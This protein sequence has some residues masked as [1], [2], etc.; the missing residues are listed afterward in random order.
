MRCALLLTLYVICNTLEAA[1]PSG[2]SSYTVEILV[3]RN[4]SGAR[5][6]YYVPS[7]GA[8][9]AE[10]KNNS[11]GSQVAQFI[12]NVPKS[13]LKLN[14]VNEKLAISGAYRP[15][16]H[17]GWTQTTSSW[18][19]RSG[20]SLDTLGIRVPGLSGYVN[21]QRGTLLH[22][23]LNLRYANPEGGAAQQINESRKIRFNEKNYFDHPAI[24]VIA[25]ITPGPK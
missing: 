18:G 13:Q 21:L 14:A 8:T 17:A 22:L 20:L 19:S 4:L 9:R 2:R 12:R 5:E 6:D 16:V 24:G 7:G 10:E 1:T 15:L 11:R 3:F 23:G 25:I